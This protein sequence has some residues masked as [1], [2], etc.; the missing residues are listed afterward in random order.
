M[1]LESSGRS[2]ADT[3]GHV[4]EAT[5][6]PPSAKSKPPVSLEPQVVGISY[7]TADLEMRGALSFSG[8]ATPR[9]LAE[10]K[11]LGARESLVLSTCNRTEVYFSGLD[12]AEVLSLLA[13]IAEVPRHSLEEH[14][15]A[16]RG[17]PAVRHM[18]RVASGLDSAVLGE[19]EILAQLKDAFSVAVEHGMVGSTLRK[20]FQ[21]SLVASKR[22]RTETSVC[23]SVT[24]VGTM[25]VRQAA[26]L[27]GG[28]KDKQVLLIG[29]GRIAERV[30]KELAHVGVAR[31][32]VTNRTPDRARKLADQY[33]LQFLP[34]DQ[35]DGALGRVDVVLTALAT[36]GPL[37]DGVR[38]S[39]AGRPLTVVDLG[40]PP[41][42]DAGERPAFQYVDM[43]ALVEVCA[44]NSEERAA[45]LPHATEIVEEELEKYEQACQERGAAPVIQALVELG[46]QVRAANLE[47]ALSRLDGLSEKE[48]KVVED[49]SIRIV[50]GMLQA[51]IQGLKTELVEPS[52]REIAARLFGV[53]SA[54]ERE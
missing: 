41:N 50:R 2:A 49:L 25:A 47:W 11:R 8:G 7:R 42:V 54:D 37:L 16:Y 53:E 21:S 29:A 9:L 46:E 33:G 20:T 31:A 28:L 14:A 1:C 10:L 6:N 30:A 32:L 45:A 48:R 27:S 5:P 22:V 12:S 39:G 35:L 36:D 13:A 34:F 26:E 17:R 15:Y 52:E 23:R 40:V 38:L 24:S 4:V 3:T 19:T 44:A 43:E 51:P 18:F